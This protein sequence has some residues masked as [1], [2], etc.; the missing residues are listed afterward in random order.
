MLIAAAVAAF[1]AQTKYR[2]AFIAEAIPT[3]DSATWSAI[4][5]LRGM[6]LKLRPKDRIVYLSNPFADWDMIFISEL[7]FRDKSLQIYLQNKAPLPAAELP[8]MEH[9][10]AFDKG[11]L[12]VVK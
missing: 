2:H 9:I 11:N 6:G 4:Q 7:V 5:Q 10:L 8:G 1:V 12:V 3:A